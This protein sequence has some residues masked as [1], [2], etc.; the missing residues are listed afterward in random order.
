MTVRSLTDLMLLDRY[1]TN[2]NDLIGEFYAPSLAQATIYDRAAGYFRSSIL[3]LAARPIADFAARGGKIRLVCSPEMTDDDIKALTKGYA[4]HATVGEV[5]RRDLDQAL[6][7][8]LGKPIVEF[9]ATLVAIGCLDIKVAFRPMGSG[10]FHDKIGAFRDDGDNAVSFTGSANETFQAW[11]PEGNHE[12]FDVFRSWTQEA[13]RVAQHLA[14]FER[15]WQGEE[16]GIEAIHFPQVAQE[17]LVAVANPEGIEAAYLKITKAQAPDGKRPQPHQVAAVESWKLRGNRGI[18]EHATGSGKTITAIIAIR[19]WLRDGGTVLVLVPSELLLEQWHRELRAEMADAPPKMLLAGA[20]NNRW[21]RESVLEGFTE[22]GGGP[23]ITLATLQTASSAEFRNRVRSG[24]HLLLVIDEV[25]RAG[26]TKLSEVLSLDAGARLGLSATPRRY[27]DPEGTRLL[28][29]YFGG[30]IPPPFTLADAIAAGRLCPYT[31]HVHPVALTADEIQRWRRLTQQIKRAFARSR[32]DEVGGT[33]LTEAT[34]L[35]LIKRADILKG[36]AAKVGLAVGLLR[37]KYEAGQRW[38][39]YCDDQAQLADVR[40]GLSAANLPND[41]YHST[42]LSDRHT[43][44]DRFATVGGILV[45]I[46]CLDEGVDIPAVDHALILASSRN[47]RE[48]IQ[49]RGRVLRISEGK[50][51]AE[52]HDVLV[53][54]PPDDED[55]DDVAILKGEIA[56]AAQFAESAYNDSVTFDLRRLAREAGI[57]PTCLIA[58]A[59]FEDEEETNA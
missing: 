49:R 14:Y 44:L 42:M 7:D 18:L 4:W 21:R 10:I 58:T 51:F 43:T 16:P 48:F 9:L 59:G 2:H 24:P 56:R 40:A 3:L 57:D 34:K 22:S 28:L 6:D 8:P 52:I 41:E 25:H 31:Y 1:A 20:G 50:F 15:L 54:P 32:S 26:S 17:R 45:A 35:L 13:A 46:K 29:D 37:S 47:P 55:P 11:S 5:L 19:D 33:T 39:I 36:A 27:G 23:R 12:S 30:I 53:M 38:L